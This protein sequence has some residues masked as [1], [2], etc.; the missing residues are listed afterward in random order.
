MEGPGSQGKMTG[1]SLKSPCRIP[2]GRDRRLMEVGSCPVSCCYN[3]TVTVLGTKVFGCVFQG[4]LK[5]D[6]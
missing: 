6:V 4:S 5:I 2:H 1:H 3:K